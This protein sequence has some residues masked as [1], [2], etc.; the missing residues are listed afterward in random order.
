VDAPPAFVWDLPPGQLRGE[1]EELVE[2][3][4]LLPLASLERRSEEVRLL[5]RRR[6]TVARLGLDGWRVRPSGAKTAKRLPP[7]LVAVPVRGFD[8][9]FARLLRFLDRQ[10][11]ERS[12][13][14]VLGT[15]YEACGLQPG[16]YKGKV[17]IPLEPKLPAHLAMRRVHRQLFDTMRRNEDGLRRDLDSEFLHD[18]RVA[19]RRTRSALSQVKGV[20]PTDRVTRFRAEFAW[21]GGQ[22]GRLRDLDVYLLK[23]DD[24]RAGL[25]VGVASDLGP[26][27]ALLRRKQKSEHRR[28]VRALDTKRYRRL[29]SEWESFLADEESPDTPPDG[30][31]PIA[32]VARDRILTAHARVIKKGRAI[33]PATADERLH[34]LRIDCKKLRYLLEFFRDLYEP[35]E[36]LSVIRALKGLQDNL[37]DFNDLSVQQGAMVHFAEELTAE[38]AR[39]AA[40][41]A[42]GQLI[43]NLSRR[44]DEE[45][46][47]FHKQFARFDRPKVHKRLSR[48]VESVIR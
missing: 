25:P 36:I 43:A 16:D 41:L 22:T 17:Q 19:V 48:L 3:R 4:R 8:R 38:R 20:L 7:R 9:D 6:K 15:A 44:H 23:L 2:M 18:F 26:L 42:L 35:N 31:I 24:Y 46:R 30:R 37:G 40:L 33:G 5:D 21:L 14:P 45:R 27:E 13:R 1:L 12:S 29:L 28:T 34:R 47:R 10:G 39:A 11:L 32:E